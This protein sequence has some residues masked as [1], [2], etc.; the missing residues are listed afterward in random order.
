MCVYWSIYD[1]DAPQY[2]PTEEQNFVAWYGEDN[3]FRSHKLYAS[4]NKDE[5]IRIRSEMI[6]ALPMPR[7]FLTNIRAP[8]GAPVQ[9]GWHAGGLYTANRS[10]RWED[11]WGWYIHML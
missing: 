7:R 10:D 5:F 3:P 11:Y 9:Q 6:A 1:W 8:R 2:T 4:E